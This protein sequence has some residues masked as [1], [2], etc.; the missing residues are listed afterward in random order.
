[1]GLRN[2]FSRKGRA[3]QQKYAQS[4]DDRSWTRIFDWTPGA[5]QTHHPYDAEQSVLGYPTV[6]SCVTLIEGSISKLRATVEK[7]SDTGI[8]EEAEHPAT[9]LLKKPNNYQNHIQF[10]EHWINSKLIHGNTYVLKAWVGNKLD[11]LH[12]LDPLKVTPLVA[13]NGD[14]YYRLGK[15]RLVPFDDADAEQIVVPANQIIHD[16]FNC[17][18]HPLVGLSPIFAAGTAAQIGLTA[19]KNNK[20]FFKNGTNPG[21]V[22]TAPGSIS[23]PTAL[24]LKEYFEANFGGEKTGKVA[25]AGDGLKYEP[26]RMSSVD[27]QMIE[28]LGWNDEK[29]CSVFH[30]PGY[31]IGVG[32]QPTHNNIEALDQGFYGQCLQI[33][34]ES[35]EAGLDEGLEIPQK[36][37]VQLDLAGLLRMDS[38]TQMKTQ[39]DGV[40]A[41][42]IA[43]NEARRVFNLPPVAGGEFP[44]LQQQNYSLEALASRDKNAPF[45][46]PEPAP[47]PDPTDLELEDESKFMAYLLEKELKIEYQTA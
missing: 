38:S 22:L 45:D 43:P 28:T 42:I 6:F 37:R 1:M 33:L 2:F 46:K 9:K 27:A 5:W 15:D 35:L 7:K 32:Q 21:G 47:E 14:V 34:I 17:L 31:K 23:E 16:R 3:E 40:K 36:H 20:N 25:V 8:W 19:Q 26:M 30:V 39:G 4:V 44:Y 13:D 41:G 24:R 18:Y 11:Q 10:K 29:I 12:I